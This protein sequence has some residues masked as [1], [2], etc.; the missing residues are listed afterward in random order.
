MAPPSVMWHCPDL[1][2]G[3]MF[4]LTHNSTLSNT[5][6]THTSTLIHMSTTSACYHLPPHQSSTT[7]HHSNNVFICRSPRFITH[8]HLPPPDLTS[9]PTSL[10][11]DAAC[12]AVSYIRPSPPGCQPAVSMSCCHA[13]ARYKHVPIGRRRVI[14]SS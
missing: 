7:G 9:I 10:H 11:P 14:H 4:A 2:S 13:A 12:Y 5:C 6:S 8:P 1:K 3:H